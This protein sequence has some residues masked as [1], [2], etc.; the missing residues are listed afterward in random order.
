MRW[1]VAAWIAA[2]S[3]VATAD[4]PR[5]RLGL[6]RAELGIVRSGTGQERSGPGY[7]LD[8]EF[9]YSIAGAFQD[10]TNRVVAGDY[11][12]WAFGLGANSDD[13]FLWARGRVELGAQTIVRLSPTCG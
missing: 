6:F 3:A 7:G 2:S 5:P 11:T 1:L 12:V 13:S 10:P 4:E 8:V 9:A